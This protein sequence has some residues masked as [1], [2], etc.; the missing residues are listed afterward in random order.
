MVMIFSAKQH[1]ESSYTKNEKAN[2]VIV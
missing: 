2:E 1:H